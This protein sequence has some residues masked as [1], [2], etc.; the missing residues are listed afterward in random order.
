M[1]K[2]IRNVAVLGATGSIGAAA[3]D[4]LAR[5]PRQF[6]VSLLAAGQRVDALLALCRTYRPD[7]AV[8][9]DATL[10]TTLRDGLNAAGLATKAYAGEAA[11]AELVASTTC[12][13]VVAA[14]V[15]A[16]GPPFDTGGS[17]RRKTSVAGEQ[18]IAGPGRNAADA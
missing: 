3:L 15:G 10:Y 14:I 9:G 11:L 16:A 12:D 4:V 5:H 17:T 18:R 8:I 7:H 2:P 13:T 6:H 1:T